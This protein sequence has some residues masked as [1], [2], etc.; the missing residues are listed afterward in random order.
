[1]M[2]LFGAKAEAEFAE[3]VENNPQEDADPEVEEE[4]PVEGEEF[5]MKDVGQAVLKEVIDGV[6]PDDRHEDFGELAD[7]DFHESMEIKLESLPPNCWG[8]FQKPE[9][10][11]RYSGCSFKRSRLMGPRTKT[12]I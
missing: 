7:E 6:A 12:T 8:R 4:S 5:M 1:M 2:L 3:E 9:F 10:V 11:Q